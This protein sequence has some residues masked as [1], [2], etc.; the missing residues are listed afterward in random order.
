MLL[1]AHMRIVTEGGDLPYP[2]PDL[3]ALLV[4]C[5]YQEAFTAQTES[6]PDPYKYTLQKRLAQKAADILQECEDLADLV[7]DIRAGL[8]EWQS[9]LLNYTDCHGHAIPDGK[10]WKQLIFGVSREDELTEADN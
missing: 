7:N 10:T 3:A 8:L 6:Q 2:L 9:H 1:Y 4:M 5:K